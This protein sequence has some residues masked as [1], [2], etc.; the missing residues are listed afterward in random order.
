MDATLPHS[1]HNF[2]SQLAP[3]VAR[4]VAYR[5][6]VH[7]AH[8]IQDR[9]MDAFSWWQKPDGQLTCILVVDGDN[10]DE[11]VL[12]EV[13]CMAKN[14]G[15]FENSLDEIFVPSCGHNAVNI[16]DPVQFALVGRGLLTGFSAAGSGGSQIIRE[17][18]ATLGILLNGFVMGLLLSASTLQELGHH[19]TAYMQ[20]PKRVQSGRVWSPPRGTAF[21][22][23]VAVAVALLT[24]HNRPVFQEGQP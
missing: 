1:K 11:A 13:G 23:A 16:D 7:F 14:A 9:A 15:L 3:L 19:L 24:R 18:A 21:T 6:R 17:R 10:I 5:A 12:R 20:A 2:G 8:I 4:Q 22:P